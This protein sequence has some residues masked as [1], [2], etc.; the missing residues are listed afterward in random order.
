MKMIQSM[1]IQLSWL[2]SF[3]QPSLGDMDKTVN[4]WKCQDYKIQLVL[5]LMCFIGLG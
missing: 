1:L 5:F 2:V 3:L 4:I